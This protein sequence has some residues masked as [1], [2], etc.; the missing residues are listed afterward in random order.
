MLFCIPKIIIHKYFITY[1]F[2]RGS[3]KF[4]TK[5]TPPSS[6]KPQKAK[7]LNHDLF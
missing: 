3:Q 5:K 2:G 7:I 4:I 6:S 1:F